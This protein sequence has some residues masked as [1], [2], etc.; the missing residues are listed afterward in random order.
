MPLP[1]TPRFGELLRRLLITKG[2]SE[3]NVLEDYFPVIDMLSDKAEHLRLRSER[4]FSVGL[5]TNATVGNFPRLWLMNRTV[6]QLVVVEHIFASVMG[7]AQALTTSFGNV[8]AA[9]PADETP[10]TP[11]QDGHPE[12]ARWNL[13]GATFGT[14]AAGVSVGHTFGIGGGPG[15]PLGWFNPTANP[16]VFPVKYVLPP[17]WALIV[18][19]QLD[20]VGNNVLVRFRGYARP[21]EDSE[22]K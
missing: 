15:P 14:G 17:N 1:Q 2:Y 20:G 5:Q 3:G 8:V 16:V 18:M 22:L 10:G 21:V 4:S 7:T 6:G 9:F 19:A 12:D 13:T 11:T